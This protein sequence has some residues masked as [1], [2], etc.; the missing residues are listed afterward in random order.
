MISDLLDLAIY[1]FGCQSGLRSC[2]KIRGNSVL[3]GTST[4]L[5]RMLL[6]LNAETQ[7]TYEKMSPIRPGNK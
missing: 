1:S 7:A 6:F 5:G 3:E 4:L 2:H